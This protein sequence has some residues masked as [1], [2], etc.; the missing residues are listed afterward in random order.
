MLAAWAPARRRCG[1][2]VARL[3]TRATFAN[4]SPRDGLPFGEVHD[5]GADE[6]EALIALGSGCAASSW[7]QRASVERRGAVLRAMAATLRRREAELARLETLDCGKPLRDS[8]ADVRMASSLFDYYA[9]A[10]PAALADVPLRLD[11]PP[12][13]ARVVPSALGLVACVTPWNYPLLQAS[14]KVAPALAA[15]CAVVL[16]PSPLASLSSA[17]LGTIAAEAG[18][19]AGA[20][21]VVTGGPPTGAADGAASLLAHARVAKLSLT[22]SDAAGVLALRAAAPLLRPTSLELGG[23]GAMIVFEDAGMPAAVHWLLAGFVANAG[24]VCSATSRLLVHRPIARALVDALADAV[25]AL[26]V[27]DPLSAQTDV[28]PVISHERRG[29]IVAAVRAAA[30]AGATVIAGGEPV[31]VPG[32]EG[33]FYVAPTLLADVPSDC[34]AWTDEIFGPVLA[35]RAF[36]TE[37]EA[38]RLANDSPYGLAHAVISADAARCERVGAALD[39]GTVWLNCAQL[40]WP[41]TPFGGWKRSGIGREYGVAGLNEYLRYKTVS[42]APA[43]HR[44]DDAG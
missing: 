31:S 7:G 1:P 21:S 42:R 17:E 25:S 12:Y 33:G 39:A 14:A 19:P 9:D 41:A 29:A 36:E 16:K 40:V 37:E 2:R 6:V 34:A 11:E 32:L 26:V 28:G 5:M 8:L 20:L 4:L 3:S 43:G 24:Q 10:A 44:V 18:A 30:A 13:E 22:G 23:K 38:V 15:G 35:I 27:G